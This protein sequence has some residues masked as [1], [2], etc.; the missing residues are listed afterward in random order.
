MSRDHIYMVEKDGSLRRMMPSAPE[1][2]DRMQTLVARY[3]ELISDGDGDLL[4]I[5]RE[6]SIADSED[7]GGRWSLDH[8]FVTREAVP[9][10]VEL[11]RAADSR[12]RREVV[13][14]MLDYAA[15]STAYWQAGRIADSFTA[16]AEDA[17]LDPESTLE[18]F[19]GEQ[20]TSAFWNQVDANFKAGRI[21]LVFVADEIPREL[22]RVVEFLNDQ[23]R[24]DVRAVELRWFAGEGG[25]TTLSPRVIGE[26]E[27]TAAIK[28]APSSPEPI[29]REEWLLKHIAPAGEEAL[30]GARAYIAMVEKLGGEAG[31]ASRQGSIFAAF[32]PTSGK[33][34]Y[35]LHLWAEGRQV[36]LTF[37]WLYQRPAFQDETTRQGLL[38]GLVGIV[39]SMT[40]SNLKGYPAF[41]VELLADR[42]RASQVEGWL[43]RLLAIA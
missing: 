10:L 14:Q 6:Q 11:K 35:P 16:T 1:S 42:A 21:K 31:V 3:P 26:T 28:R 9:V 39:G 8:L 15:N 13:G 18:E 24:A 40:T 4:L 23:M 7:G 25:E 32:R 38:D 17:G 27:R 43:S 19:V 2:E 29:S 41:K 33:T 34:F 37:R 5:R 30:A 12:L 22:A 36:S 20:E